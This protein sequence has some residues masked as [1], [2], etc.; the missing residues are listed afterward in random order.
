MES[1]RLFFKYTA[2]YTN[3]VLSRWLAVGQAVGYE[4]NG[5]SLQRVRHQ[6]PAESSRVEQVLDALPIPVYL[7]IFIIVYIVRIYVFCGL[8]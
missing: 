3:R 6:S 5:R 1:T 4:E 8:R 2:S 7:H